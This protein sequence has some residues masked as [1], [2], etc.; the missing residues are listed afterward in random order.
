MRN[1]EESA[2]FTLS[3]AA[4]LALPEGL[5]PPRSHRELHD[6]WTGLSREDR[7][8]LHRADPFIGNRD[9]I[10]QVDRDHYNR[11]TLAMLQE[12]A[13]SA[14]DT[15]AVKRY[16]K[17]ARA[18]QPR[19]GMPRRYLSLVDDKFRVAI[20]ADNPDEATH[21]LT[22]L[23]PA[24]VNPITGGARLDKLRQAAL[25]V[26]P[27]A[28]TSV[29]SWSGY[30]GAPSV[31]RAIE[32][33]HARNSAPVLRSY[34]EGLRVT[35]EGPPSHNT[36]LG[37]SYGSVTAGH[38]AAY[39]VPLAADNIIFA[40]SFGTGVERASDLRLA[41]VDPA[42]IDRHVFSTMAEHDWI[43]LMPKTH[44]TPPT[45]PSFGGTVFSTDSAR[46]P[47]NSLGWNPH[48]HHSYWDTSN[49]VMKNMGLIVTGHGNLV[50]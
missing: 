26:D 39:E 8:T 20:A 30:E 1:I 22:Y 13:V 31:S 12:R 16:G 9:G 5:E 45:S 38:A 36:V 46:G 50:T 49:Q 29:I 47:W 18:L 35:H 41:G 34:Q 3:P 19:E 25:A 4:R 32:S 48:D 23:A 28:R 14:S 37:Y 15:E 43:Q 24:G 17:I 21:V 7:D 6:L 40:G 11:Q 44:G 42:D 10:P 33:V 2:S 27:H